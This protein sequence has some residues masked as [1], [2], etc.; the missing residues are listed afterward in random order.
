MS[1]VV[2]SRASPVIRSSSSSAAAGLTWPPSR[3]FPRSLTVSLSSPRRSLNASISASIRGSVL[4]LS[5]VSATSSRTSKSW[6]IGPISCVHTSC[7]P[8]AKANKSRAAMIALSAS[9]RRSICARISS[10]SPPDASLSDAK[11]PCGLCSVIR[12][13]TLAR[14]ARAC[15]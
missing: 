4:T 6:M 14:S 2:R 13:A 9:A 11:K 15:S 8:G 10:S 3:R 5:R 7:Q 1:S 12:A